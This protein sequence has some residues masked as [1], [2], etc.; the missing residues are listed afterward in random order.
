M[1]RLK[2]EGEST[3]DN[4]KVD[5]PE[6]PEEL[7]KFKEENPDLFKVVEQVAKLQSQNET[8]AVK[9]QLSD[10]TQ[11]E[12]A[13]AR[14]AAKEEV[15]KSH[16]DLDEV[17][18][19]DEFHDWA[20]SQ[21]DAIQKMIYENP[22]DSAALIRALDFYKSDTSKNT[23]SRSKPEPVASD[24][25]DALVTTRPT[26]EPTNQKK[27]WSRAEIARLT[28]AQFDRYEKEIDQALLEGRITQ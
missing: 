27:V 10:L 16:P 11:R 14:R 3:T 2:G 24:D 21:P 22:T 1:N 8:K 9:E 20:E 23:A 7:L 6:T 4:K 28:P 26:G 12:Q 15:L 19:S 5:A 18:S 17:T 13:L 25:V